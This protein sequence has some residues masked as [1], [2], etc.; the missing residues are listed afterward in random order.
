MSGIVKRA[1]IDTCRRGINA[2][3]NHPTGGSIHFG[4]HDNGIV[5]EGLDLEQNHVID[6]L[7]MKVGEV[8]Q[9][10]WPP[11]ESSFAQVEPVEL[12]N[13]KQELTGRWRFD[14]IVK[15]H[16]TVVQFSQ[17]ETAYYRQGPRN[18]RMTVDV[19]VSRVRAESVSSSAP[20]VSG[21]AVAA[22]RS[23]PEPEC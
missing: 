15:P 20:V 11:V 23:P 3:L 14:I 5:E 4:I 2:M 13:S 12:R 1:T 17:K 21:G 8:L 16:K 6:K 22:G 7:R 19:L 18:V 10:F 9:N